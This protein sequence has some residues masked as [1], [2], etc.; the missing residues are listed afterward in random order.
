[1]LFLTRV[2][3]SRV[4]LITAVSLLVSQ[5]AGVVIAQNPATP[6]TTAKPAVAAASPAAPRPIDGGWPRSYTTNS[7]AALVLYQP[8]VA[9]WDQQKLMTAYAAA[10][11]TPVGAPKPAL[12]T[13]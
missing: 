6:A 7:G 11:Y 8:Q 12:G 3:Q 9:T 4:A 10:S 5:N 1:M 13:L 2:A